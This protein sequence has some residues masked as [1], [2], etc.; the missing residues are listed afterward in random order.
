MLI[1][2]QSKKVTGRFSEEEDK[3]LLC[4]IRA[5]TDVTSGPIS[6]DLPIS[7]TQVA[8]LLDNVRTPNH[9]LKRWASLRLTYQSLELSN[10]DN[11]GKLQVSCCV[12]SL[13]L[14]VWL[15]TDCQSTE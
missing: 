11:A 8:A 13:R 15:G 7:W 12:I 10:L 6:S 3:Q 2:I 4:A 14:L 9:Y 1:S 5:V